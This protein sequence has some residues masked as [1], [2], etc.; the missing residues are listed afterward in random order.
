MAAPGGGR[1][2]SEAWQWFNEKSAQ[3]EVREL[4]T[5]IGKLPAVPA[6]VKEVYQGLPKVSGSVLCFGCTGYIGEAV[7][8]DAVRRGLKVTVFIRPKSVDRFTAHLKELKIQDKVSFQTGEVSSSED[9]EKAMQDTQAECVISLLASPQITDEQNIFDVDYKASHTVVQAARKC[10]VKH[11]IYCSDTGVYQPSLA[12]QFHKLR[13]EG[14]LMRCTPDGLQW[15]V[16]RPTTYHPYVVSAIVLDQVRHGQDVNLFGSAD[17]A[18][19][20]AVYN[21]IARE[22]LGRFIVSC[23]NNEDTFGR[24][25]AVGGPWSADN[26][27]TLGDI[28]KMMISMATPPGA[29]PSKIKPLGMNLSDIIYKAMEAIGHFSPTL[30]KVATI[31]FFYTK[32]WSTVSHFSPAT[33]VY[34]TRTYTSE[35]VD[36]VKK[37][38]QAFSKFIENAKK[39][40]TGSIVY[41]TPRN[42]WWD[43]S[44]PSLSP[45]QMPMGA[46]SGE[47][48][49]SSQSADENP[50]D[51]AE[52]AAY[53]LSQLRSMAPLGI[54]IGDLP[55]DAKDEPLIHVRDSDDEADGW[56][57]VTAGTKGISF[58]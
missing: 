4:K 27:A 28:T 39:S 50:P 25:L 13:I 11:F 42:S 3:D 20:L 7:V 57:N 6:P 26:V 23:V 48:S 52:A 18:G 29:K 43:I 15:T 32:Y 10:G 46:G 9:V 47:P 58:H 12:C 16:V 19:D 49:S 30:K 55:E 33:G 22:D 5:H 51:R 40:T 45:E 54:C 41:P 14:E 53:R 31:V 35:L 37:D 56:I 36:A 17:D 2:N 38:P 44:E 21:P 1:L 24:V 8:F 34:D